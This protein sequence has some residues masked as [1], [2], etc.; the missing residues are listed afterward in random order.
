MQVLNRS[1]FTFNG[2]IEDFFSKVRNSA[3]FILKKSNW[4]E[5]SRKAEFRIDCKVPMFSRYILPLS[6]DGE[7]ID[8]NGFSKLTIG[9]NYN[10]LFY[11]SIAFLCFVWGLLLF[12]SNLAVNIFIF[13]MI[14]I[15]YLSGRFIYT[16]RYFL[17]MFI[18]IMNLNE[19]GR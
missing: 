9:A 14:I 2:S 12:D 8:S 11:F 13:G 19:I 1:E 15:V 7:I 4:I 5:H 18:E 10:W 3:F 6:F 16:C 17:P